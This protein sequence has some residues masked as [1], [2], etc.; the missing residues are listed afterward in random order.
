MIFAHILLAALYLATSWN[1]SLWALKK[2]VP[3]RQLS[4]AIGEHV[5]RDP[6]RWHRR[7]DV[8][9]AGQIFLEYVVLGGPCDVLSIHA[10]LLCH[11]R[12][13]EQENRGGRVYRHRGRD[14]LQRDA[15]EEVAHVQ[16]RVDGYADL[17]DLPKGELMVRVASH[18]RGQ[19]EGH[20]EACL[21]VLYQVLEAGV[22]LTRRAET[23]V[24]AHGPWP[25]AIHARVRA[26]GVRILSR[27]AE[28]LS[29]VEAFEVVGLVE[30]LDFDPGLRVALVVAFLGVHRVSSPLVSGVWQFY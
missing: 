9:A 20:R 21:T 13:E 4:C 14:L 3:A 1:R 30:G 29:V 10:L 23:R 8:G 24:L 7:V 6:H 25:A 12:V 16:E 15:F 22:R 27:V 18:L 5:G 17:A 11:E 2:S 26:A 28:T 19:V